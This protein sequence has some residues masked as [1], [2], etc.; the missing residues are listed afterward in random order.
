VLEAI[1]SETVAGES[2]GL[3][4]RKG[5]CVLTR[6]LSFALGR[7][8]SVSLGVIPG[9]IRGPIP[10]VDPLRSIGPDGVVVDGGGNS[11]SIKLASISKT[12]ISESSMN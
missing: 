8:A 7:S 5:D 6:S 9:G 4:S 10:G 11:N 1:G 12:Y 3:V 2:P